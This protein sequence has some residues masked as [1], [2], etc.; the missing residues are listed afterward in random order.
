[1]PSSHLIPDP[2]GRPPAGPRPG[3]RA[4][5]R[6]GAPHRPPRHRAADV[7]RLPPPRRP[8]G[9][10]RRRGRALPGGRVTRQALTR[11]REVLLRVAVL[12]PTPGPGL[13]WQSH[14]FK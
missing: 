11:R 10:D 1:M 5:G 12:P 3:R 13:D 6:A 9:A 14:V 7:R 4:A 8:G 2:P